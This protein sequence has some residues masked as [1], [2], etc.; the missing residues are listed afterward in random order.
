MRNDERVR[1]ADVLRE[2]IR[3][4]RTMINSALDTRADRILLLAL[5]NVLLDRLE[6]LE[7][8]ER[9]EQ[10]RARHDRARP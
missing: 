8:L 10:L 6:A 1:A 2:D 5:S 7:E 9:T 3:V 4:L